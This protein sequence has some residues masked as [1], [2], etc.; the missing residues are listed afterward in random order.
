MCI[1]MYIWCRQ[2][3]RDLLHTLI[4]PN[5]LNHLEAQ[6]NMSSTQKAQVEFLLLCVCACV[7]VRVRVCAVCVC[8]Y[9]LFFFCCA[10]CGCVYLWG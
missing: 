4:P 7:Y 1:C 10:V 9:R 6:G 2:V 5:V 8:A 3:N